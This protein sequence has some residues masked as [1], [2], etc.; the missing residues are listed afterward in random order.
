MTQ[1]NLQNQVG[2]LAKPWAQFISR[3][4]IDPGIIA[5]S[6]KGGSQAVMVIDLN[7]PDVVAGSTGANP[8]EGVC[9]Q[10]VGFAVRNRVVGELGTISRT[11]PMQ[12]PLFP[13]LW[14]TKISK[15]ESFGVHIYSGN[16]Q[17]AGLSEVEAYK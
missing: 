2:R 9:Q 3:T 12:H 14:C 8:I 6:W 13:N 10:I 5:M 15:L 4:G 7:F 11:L 17:P 16:S 1:P